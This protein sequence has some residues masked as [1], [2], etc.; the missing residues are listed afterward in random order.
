LNI[1][2]LEYSRTFNLG[3]YQSEKIT[4][5]AILEIEKQDDL[6]D[7]YQTLKSQVF[8]LHTLKEKEKDKEED[9][10]F[11][12]EN[13]KWVRIEGK[14]GVY[15]RYPAF[16]QEPLQTLDYLYLLKDLQKHEGR[17]TRGGLFFWLFSDGITIGRKPIQK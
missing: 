9:N 7:A 17:L 1:R 10:Y 4:L 8:H 6:D 5:K 14:N 2:E 3:S 11:N 16:Q 12:P 15:E 13:I